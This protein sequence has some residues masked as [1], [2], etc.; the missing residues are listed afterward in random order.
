MKHSILVLLSIV[1]EGA[2]L[3]FILGEKEQRCFYE[4][5]HN[6]VMVKFE[7]NSTVHKSST[8]IGLH[9]TM[10][11]PKKEV[12]LSKEYGSRSVVNFRTNEPG[13]YSMCV[14]TNSTKW[15]MYAKGIV[16]IFYFTVD[17]GV[18]IRHL[19]QIYVS[20]TLKMM[21]LDVC[22]KSKKVYIYLVEFQCFKAL[23]TPG[24]PISTQV[25]RLGA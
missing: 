17:F 1:H 11:S 6:D 10:I 24:M 2:A 13:Q 9:V 3:F 12:M 25:S 8:P 21:H 15:A 5:Y 20:K 19:I 7:F 14:K 22:L 23:F 18:A 16:A 4:D